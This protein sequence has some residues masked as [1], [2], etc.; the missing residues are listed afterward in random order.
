LDIVSVHVEKAKPYH[1]HQVV[2][3]KREKYNAKYGA[4]HNSF[5][6]RSL[7]KKRISNTNIL[8]AEAGLKAVQ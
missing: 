5:E 3:K 7:T 4:F 8:K 1:V 2:G 6:N